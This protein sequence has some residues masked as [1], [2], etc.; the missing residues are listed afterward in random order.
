MNTESL[1]LT[2]GYTIFILFASFVYRVLQKE[3]HYKFFMAGLF[4]KLLGA[5][6]F[7][8][9]YYYYY[10]YGDSFVYFNDSV[11]LTKAL[12]NDFTA[13]LQMLL[14]NAKSFHSDTFLY[15]NQMQLFDRANDTY[16]VVKVAAIVNLLSFSNYF[17]STLLFSFFSFFGMW[18][19]FETTVKL[20]PSLTNKMAFAIL[21]IPSV[22]FWGSGLMKD[23]LVIGFMGY[24][25]YYSEKIINENNFKPKNIAAI[26]IC[27]YVIGTVK[28]YVLLCLVPTI[29]IWYAYTYKDK[30]KNKV[31]KIV[32]LPIIFV[33]FFAASIVS[34]F[35]LSSF[36]EAYAIDK[37][38]NTAQ[39]YQTNHY[40][41]G[42]F[43]VDGRGSSYTLGNYENSTLGLIIMLPA[44]VNVTLFRPYPWE[45]RNIIMTFTALESFIILLFTIHIIFNA[46]AKRLWRLIKND[47]FILMALLFSI[48]FAYSV[49]FTSYNFGALARYKIPCIPF[50]LIVLFALQ[51]EVKL[52]LKIKR[53][54]L[55]YKKREI[56]LKKAA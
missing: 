4:V 18:R 11:I 56:A 7:C 16:F 8:L 13:G 17:T 39:S 45:V 2:I 38:M 9:V 10:G 36:S 31:I 6:G 44:A 3:K 49:G 35:Y 37:L 12:Q 1:I 50:Y 30:I 51:H 20:Y 53:H 48:L 42:D 25:I 47:P 24:L 43:S 26:L 22:F 29:L 21:F 5:I 23:T 14:Q 41:D 54:F 52:E 19:F 46:G 34:V 32:V 33:L 28:L 40:G 55:T 27:I 15:T